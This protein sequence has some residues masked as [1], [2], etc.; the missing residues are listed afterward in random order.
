DGVGQDALMML[1]N[2]RWARVE[3]QIAMAVPAHALARVGLRDGIAAAER[4]H[5]AARPLARLENRAAIACLAQLV[6]G[7]HPRDAG[8]EDGDMDPA[9]RTGRQLR[10]AGMSARGGEKPHGTERVVERR[11]AAGAPG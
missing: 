11:G 6:A 2:S 4:P 1:G 9:A 8:A 7:R 5:A 10:R 3:I